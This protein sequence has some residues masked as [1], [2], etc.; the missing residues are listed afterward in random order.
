MRRIYLRIYYCSWVDTSAG[1]LLVLGGTICPVVSASILTWFIR[2]VYIC[3][4][5]SPF[6][7]NTIYQKVAG[8]FR[9]III[10]CYKC[11]H[12]NVLSKRQVWMSILHIINLKKKIMDT[13][14]WIF[15]NKKLILDYYLFVATKA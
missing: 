10:K 5:K 12:R 2:Y 14:S 9:Q 4:W 6:R 7:N 3:I 15:F 8:I 13:G 11:G 1:G